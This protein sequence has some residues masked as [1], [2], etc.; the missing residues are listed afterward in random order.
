MTD[1][2]TSKTSTTTATTS[3]AKTFAPI[4]QL[5]K[6]SWERVKRTWKQM[7]LL[8]LALVVFFAVVFGGTVTFFIASGVAFSGSPEKLA[9]VVAGGM[10]AALLLGILSVAVSTVFQAAL[11]LAV[12]E[13][14]AYPTLGSKIKRGFQ[15]FLPL[16]ATSLITLFLVMGGMG[17]LII[18]GIAIAILVSYTIYEIVLADTRMMTA[19][20]N[21]VTIIQ[22][23]FGEVFVRVIIIFLISLGIS[24]VLN[25][26]QVGLGDNEASKSLVG[27]LN[28]VISPVFAFFSLAYYYQVYKEARDM[29]DFSRP[30]SIVWMWI[31]SILGWMVGVA[32]IIAIAGVA[33]KAIESTL[34]KDF[35]SSYS[36][37]SE[38][39][40]MMESE[41]NADSFLENYG[42][43]MTDEQQAAFKKSMEKTQK[44]MEDDAMMAQ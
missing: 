44:M 3:M 20:R 27:L 1:T 11:L 21:S 9:S 32:L 36:Q 31:V 33:G 38:D 29:T 2:S 15:L 23:N 12:S 22:Q 41:F 28:L 39:S 10:I 7:V 6:D 13:S 42:D 5:M 4:D 17:L 35:S 18:P 30:A 34:E 25:L 16:F 26:L 19:I 14:K 40:M 43:E 24:I 37:D 8:Y